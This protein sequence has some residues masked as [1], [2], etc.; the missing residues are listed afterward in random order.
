MGTSL[1]SILR[2][3]KLLTFAH[4][5]KIAGK[6]ANFEEAEKREELPNA[7]LDWSPRKT[8]FVFG[9]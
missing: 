2:P 7:I 8:P 9:L 5:A 6:W 1:F 3:V 4:F